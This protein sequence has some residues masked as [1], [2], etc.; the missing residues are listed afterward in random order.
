MRASLGLDSF[1]VEDDPEEP[2][3]F[4]C[5]GD[6]RF[7]GRLTSEGETHE[8]LVEANVGAIGEGEDSSGLSFAPPAERE[9]DRGPMA[10]MPGGLDE[11]VSGMR[12]PSPGDGSALLRLPCRSYKFRPR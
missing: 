9:A 7:L 10:V 6:D 12:V 5:D 11:E 1:G 8:A 3:E 4:S 2:G